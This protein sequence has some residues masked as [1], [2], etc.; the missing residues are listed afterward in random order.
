ME[1]LLH[2]NLGQP[3]ARFD[4]RSGCCNAAEEIDDTL[5]ELKRVIN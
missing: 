3:A 1:R 2:S 4:F 5:V